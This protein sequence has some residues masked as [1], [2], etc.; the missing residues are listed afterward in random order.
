MQ[1]EHANKFLLADVQKDDLAAANNVKHRNT[2]S[3]HAMHSISGLGSSTTVET[4]VRRLMH[5]Y[6]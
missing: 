6:S 4:Y 1:P 5:A 3:I 2:K